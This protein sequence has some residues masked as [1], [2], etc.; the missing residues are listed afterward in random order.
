[1]GNEKFQIDTQVQPSKEGLTVRRSLLCM[2][3]AGLSGGADFSLKLSKGYPLSSYRNLVGF[4]V[5]DSIVLETI[6]E[7]ETLEVEI[8]L[9]S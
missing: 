8:T 7:A 9:S 2:F 5:N 1:M 4:N 6:F 3:N